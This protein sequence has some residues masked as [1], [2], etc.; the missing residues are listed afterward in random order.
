MNKKR[1]ASLNLCYLQSWCYSDAVVIFSL[2]YSEEV[3]NELNAI[4]VRG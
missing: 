1:T 2:K 4:A 3:T